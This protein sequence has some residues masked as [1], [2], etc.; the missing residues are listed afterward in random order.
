[1][2]FSLALATLILAGCGQVANGAVPDRPTT[3]PSLPTVAISPVASATPIQL[4]TT[5]QLSAPSA[6][7]LWAR[8]GETALFRSLDRGASWSRATL[9]PAIAVVELSFVDANEGWALV[10]ASPGTQCQGQEAS[11]WHTSDA[12]LTWANLKASGIEF[13]QCKTALAFHDA[14]RGYLVSGDATAGPSLYRTGDGGRTWARSPVPAPLGQAFGGTSTM[15]LVAVRQLAETVYLSAEG[16][17]HSYVYTSG[18]GGA[19]WSFLET[20][21]TSVAE[22][23]VVRFISARFWWAYGPG[24]ALVTRDGGTTWGAPPGSARFAAGVGPT[25]LFADEKV[26]YATVRGGIQR[27]LDG[28]ATWEAIRTPGT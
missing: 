19:T 15:H 9:P 14:K 5:A 2:R 3:S 16:F 22:P 13:A 4:P 27:T 21:P 12:G 24:P 23:A 8:V 7:V 11:I 18:D 25:Y 10:T 1:M 26:G 6:D 28:G 20:L 17:G